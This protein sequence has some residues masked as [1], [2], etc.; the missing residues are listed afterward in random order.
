[1]K[2]NKFLFTLLTIAIVFT[3]AFSVSPDL[4]EGAVT[5]YSG[6]ITVDVS[7]GTFTDPTSVDFVDGN[8]VS[9]I[10]A[11][12]GE[13]LNT[14]GL[15]A[16]AVDGQKG[17]IILEAR[18]PD[19]LESFV[20]IASTNG[21]SYNLINVKSNKTEINSTK[22]DNDTLIFCEGTVPCVSVDADEHEITIANLIV[23][24][25]ATFT[26]RIILPKES[27]LTISGDTVT[28]TGGP[29][30]KV[31]TESL[32]AADDLCNINGGVVGQEIYLSTVNSARDVTILDSGSCNID[33]SGAFTL[34]HIN[35]MVKLYYTASGT[36]VGIGL[37]NNH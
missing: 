22:R 6:G 7:G 29:Y 8:P 15:T 3:M 4:T 5:L 27:N 19:S 13:G 33:I 12:S 1:M 31:D 35:D 25:S 11:Y 18:S 26:D 32:A 17:K 30:F 24:G 21:D 28:I 9:N 36:W 23:S 37:F 16:F 20:H 14:L 34:D 2:N 10:F